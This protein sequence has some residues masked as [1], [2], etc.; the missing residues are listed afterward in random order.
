MK[1]SA[2]WAWDYTIPLANWILVISPCPC[3]YFY[4]YTY[5]HMCR[6]AHNMHT[7]ICVHTCVHPNIHM[8]AC[9]DTC[10]CTLT[11]IHAHVHTH[12]HTQACITHMHTHM[13]KHI[14]MHIYTHIHLGG[15]WPNVIRVI[16]IRQGEFEGWGEYRAGGREEKK[17]E[18][19]KEWK[20]VIGEKEH[21]K[22]GE[23]TKWEVLVLVLV[24]VKCWVSVQP[25]NLF[26]PT[27]R[28]ARN[29]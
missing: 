19:G 29:L 11:H 25:I 18:K 28:Y 13:H 15:R 5:T 1:E 26:W 8:H 16:T 23:S 21:L 6:H 24:L 20:Q 10:T 9:A 12:A 2:G 22:P 4:P 3:L 7:H 14:H 27:T 17:G